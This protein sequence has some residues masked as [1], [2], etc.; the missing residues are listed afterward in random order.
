MTG[1]KISTSQV[2]NMDI[3]SQS[4]HLPRRREWDGVQ[5]EWLFQ[6]ATNLN[7]LENMTNIQVKINPL[8]NIFNYQK[9]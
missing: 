4:V 6:P 1:E 3:I 2:A 5:G 8:P 9:L 7:L